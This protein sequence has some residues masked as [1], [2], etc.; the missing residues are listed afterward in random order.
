MK[1]KDCQTFNREFPEKF[2]WGYLNSIALS[3]LG[4]SLS[5]IID[6]DIK[7]SDRNLV[8]GL[9]RALL[10]IAEVADM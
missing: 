1:L 5:C 6:N 7:S 8:P 9:R 3:S 4:S 10:E 2:T